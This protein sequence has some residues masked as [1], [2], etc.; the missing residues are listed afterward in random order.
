M[1]ETTKIDFVLLW[2]NGNDPEWRKQRN[3]YASKYYSNNNYGN[4]EERFREWDQLKYWFRGVDKNAPW[5]NRIH[6]VTCGHLPDWLNLT[7]PKIHIVKHEDIIPNEYLPVFSSRPV[8][9]CIRNIDGLAEQFVYFNDDVFMLTPVK[10]SMFFNQGLPCCNGMID[11]FP[12]NSSFDFF[13][14][15]VL[16]QDI[17]LINK[18]F[19]FRTVIKKHWHKFFNPVYGL[20][21]NLNAFLYLLTGI[22]HFSYFQPSH[23][24]HPFLKSVFDEVWEKEEEILLNTCSHRFREFD[25]V[26][27]YLFLWWQICKGV[28]VPAKI[29][30]FYSFFSMSGNLDAI[31]TA[32]RR[33]ETPFICLN[34]SVLSKEE[35]VYKKEMINRVFDSIFPEKSSFEI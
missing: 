30:E 1:G 35:F 13:W 33:H 10:E 28:F 7:H 24:G 16:L 23:C 18:N 4:E 15:C 34:D 6:F 26:N 17:K 27:Q 5:V 29:D 31:C 14:S 11:Q 21:Q 25:D 3:Y 8:E 22:N 32:L 19:K 9:L 20:R 12:T 2:V